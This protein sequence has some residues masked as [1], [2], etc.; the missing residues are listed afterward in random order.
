MPIL[1]SL[2]SALFSGLAG[3]VLK[4]F[5]VKTSLR[6]VGIAAVLAMWGA[7]LLVFNGFLSPLVGQLFATQFGQFLGL[8]FPPVAGTCLAIIAGA[9]AAVQAYRMKRRFVEQTTGV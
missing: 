8:A 9:S 4:L 7:L 6:S 2:L 1:A 3:V 5:L